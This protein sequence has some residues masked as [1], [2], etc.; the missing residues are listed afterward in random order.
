MG[1]CTELLAK[2]LNNPR[3]LRF[4]ELCRLAE[5]GGFEFSRQRGSHRIYRNRGLRRTISLQDRG[6]LAKAYQVRQLLR[7]IMEPGG[8]DE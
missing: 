1:N 7:M 6:G 2:A 4:K 3:G 8:P 5:C